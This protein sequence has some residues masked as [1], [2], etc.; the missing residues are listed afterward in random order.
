MRFYYLFILIIIIPIQ[1]FI[2]RNI[3]NLFDF[4]FLDQFSFNN[5]HSV[6]ELFCESS[7]KKCV[8]PT[9]TVN[10]TI[11]PDLSWYVIGETKSFPTGRPKKHTIWGKDYVIWKDKVTHEYY[12]M[13][14]DCSHK[15]AALSGGYCK[16]YINNTAI[17]CPYH[18]YEFAG[19]GSL[20]KV[21]GLTFESSDC[22][23]QRT[24]P[25]LEKNGWIYIN[26]IGK[27]EYLKMK[28]E[29]H[30]SAIYGEPEAVNPDFSPIFLNVIFN[31]YSRI[32]TEN[33]LDIMHIGF[34]HTFG[35]RQF[36]SPLKEIPP[37]TVG[38]PYHYRTDYD[39]LS[40][41]NSFANKLFGFKELKIQNEFVLPHTTVARILF[42][43]FV[44]TVIT[45]ATPINITHSK[46]FVK[47]YRNYWKQS[48]Y[49]L[50][51][52]DKINQIIGDYFTKK[53]M[54][55]TVLQDK[56]VIEGI[57]LENADGK[58]NMKY[59]KLSNTYRTFYKK[60]IHR[61]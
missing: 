3:R 25:I 47:T 12:A 11:D 55:D 44:S 24:Y 20:L 29:I 58:F 9:S 48:M 26:T 54:W 50:N 1:S 10:S 28:P 15:G 52:L 14:N 19:N 43:P 13:N 16:N 51:P 22:K 17:V 4:S 40:G 18:G 21:P 7:I 36:P 38:S 37:H 56:S 8:N 60:L 57:R 30:K 27:D 23:N 5:P 59:D 35:N 2:I 42:G 61:V 41:S 32:V 53:I 31:A 45:F 39:Y 46:L 33:S 49:S 34:V 6:Q